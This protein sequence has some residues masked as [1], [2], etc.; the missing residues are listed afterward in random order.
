MRRRSLTVIVERRLAIHPH[1]CNGR[2]PFLIFAA[3]MTRKC[4][5]FSVP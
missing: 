5:V 3:Q 1:R 2:A 4:D